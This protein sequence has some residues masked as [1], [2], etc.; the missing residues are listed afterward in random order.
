MRRMIAAAFLALAFGCLAVPSTPV[1]A[2]PVID[3]FALTHSPE[4]N[5]AHHTSITF[6]RGSSHGSASAVV[7]PPSIVMDGE[8]LRTESAPLNVDG[9][10]LVPMRGI[11]EALGAELEW[12]EKA[13]AV[14]VQREHNLMK[15][16]AGSN[17]AIHNGQAIDLEVPAILHEGRMYIPLRF[18]SE[19][20]GEEVSWD[21]DTATAYINRTVPHTEVYQ[22]RTL[23]SSASI[24]EAA[25]NRSISA[26]RAAWQK[27]QPTYNGE[28]FVD[29]PVL[30]APYQ[31][32]QLNDAF[33]QDGVRM[34]NF[35][36]YLAGLPDNLVAD[37]EL[38]R[39]A[40]HGAVL[41]SAHG[42]LTHTPDKPA[43]M[44]EAFYEKGYD[45]TTSS[46]ISYYSYST[47]GDLAV[48]NRNL[49]SKQVLT[50]ANSVRLYMSDEDPMNLPAVG[51]RRWILNPRLQRIGFG[52]SEQYSKDGAW[53]TI[54]QFS[55]M[56]IL[57]ESS[58]IQ[59]SSSKDRV[60]WPNEGNFPV[61]F[62]GGR[63]P[64]S[65]SLNPDHYQKPEIKQVN[66]TLVSVRDRN[67]WT[68]QH[69][70]EW[71]VAGITDQHNYFTVNTE[72]YGIP[73][74]VIFRPANITSYRNGDIY[75]VTVSGLKDHAGQSIELKYEVHFFNLNVPD[76]F[77]S[78]SSNE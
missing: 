67:R 19:G 72:A 24:E 15:L 33:I 38:N 26:I 22:P 60:M 13:K 71:P 57:P 59:R 17:V 74:T 6:Q 34:A 3:R 65:L 20:L 39:K 78:S 40:Q 14:H 21:P 77:I 54:K 76:N 42:A 23:E 62:L 25:A 18:V 8:K 45:S 53:N 27:Y 11:F 73:Y 10:I 48:L 63:D 12:E 70:D 66:V 51:H 49:Q 1:Q 58:N 68:F 75:Q 29:S 37:E 55:T 56:Q 30:T 52:Y 44:A 41:L 47:T 16:T 64:W 2:N 36:R 31:T 7:K 5:L 46:N 4:P 69:T 43:D 32:G 50:P 61:Q 35:V 28:P 9:H